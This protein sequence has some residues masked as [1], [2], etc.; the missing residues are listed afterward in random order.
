[1]RLSILFA[2]FAL[3]LS[4]STLNF[5]DDK[6]TCTLVKNGNRLEMTN[7]GLHVPGLHAALETRLSNLES[8][9]QK[10]SSLESRMNS[11]ES[12]MSKVPSG[13]IPIC[14]WGENGNA[15]H[16]VCQRPY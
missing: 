11:L 15:M 6:G 1:M 3:A 16:A 14:K 8:K 5:E 9:V 12:K 7:C 4:Q 13:K 2:L 10:L